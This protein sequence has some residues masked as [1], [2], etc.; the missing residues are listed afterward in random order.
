MLS[1]INVLHLYFFLSLSLY[2]VYKEYYSVSINGIKQNKLISLI[3]RNIINII[4]N[5]KL[6]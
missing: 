2:D 1:Y 4:K 5:L 6:N 3:M